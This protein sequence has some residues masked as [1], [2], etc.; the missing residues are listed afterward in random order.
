MIRYAIAIVRREM[1]GSTMV[2]ACEVDRLDAEIRGTLPTF[3]PNASAIAAELLPSTS[4]EIE[5][6]GRVKGAATIALH[7]AGCTCEICKTLPE[8]G[9]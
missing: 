8:E 5:L 3:D 7:P 1:D 2:R 9:E 4:P 6:S